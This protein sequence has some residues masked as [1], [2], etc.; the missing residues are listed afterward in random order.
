MFKWIVDRWWWCFS[1]HNP[2]FRRHVGRDASRLL[3]RG[4]RPVSKL[5]I[6]RHWCR[7]RIAFDSFQSPV[8]AVED[9]RAR[10]RCP[11][12]WRIN[13]YRVWHSMFHKHQNRRRAVTRSRSVGREW[14]D[15]SLC[16]RWYSISSNVDTWRTV[17]HH[18]HDTVQSTTWNDLREEVWK[19]SASDA[20]WRLIATHAASRR[21]SH[22]AG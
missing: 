3:T 12:R 17:D 9:G 14:I 7:R 18:W 2:V 6:P 16:D 11:R 13:F 15:L 20:D 22:W 1:V 5:R 19:C 10:I 21:C 8:D 4:C